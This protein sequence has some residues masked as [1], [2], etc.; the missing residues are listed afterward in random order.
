MERV[1]LVPLVFVHARN[2]VQTVEMGEAVETGE[3]VEIANI[4]AVLMHIAEKTV[5]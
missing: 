1:V 3:T 2:L 5:G 4:H